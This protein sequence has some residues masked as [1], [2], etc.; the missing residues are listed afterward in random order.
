MSIIQKYIRSSWMCNKLTMTCHDVKNGDFLKG[1]LKLIFVVNLACFDQNFQELKG[2]FTNDIQKKV[3]CHNIF[4]LCNITQLP[5]NDGSH[6][7]TNPN[8]LI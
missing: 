3:I 5:L 8:R 1:H 6:V 4:L 2:R 7:E